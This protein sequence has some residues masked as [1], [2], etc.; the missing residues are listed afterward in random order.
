MGWAKGLKKSPEVR[1]RM[2][3]GQR[4]RWANT[5]VVAQK[6]LEKEKELDRYHK[7][8]STYPVKLHVIHSP[9]EKKDI[10][11]LCRED[12]ERIISSMRKEHMVDLWIILDAF[13]RMK[14]Q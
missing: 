12:C 9:V 1:A 3:E 11:D 4:R 14:N 6:A 5:D 13:R 10:R 7:D 2:A 8:L